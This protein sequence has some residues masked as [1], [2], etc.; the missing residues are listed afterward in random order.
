VR[1]DAGA[2]TEGIEAVMDRDAEGCRGMQRDAEGCRGMQRDREV[3]GGMGRYGEG[4]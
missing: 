2:E 3:W 4:Q 1:I